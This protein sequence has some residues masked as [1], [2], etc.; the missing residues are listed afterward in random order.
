MPDFISRETLIAD[1]GYPCDA[2]DWVTNGALAGCGVSF[3]D[4]RVIAEAKHNGW[5]ILEG[6]EYLK[7]VVVCGGKAN[8]YRAI[9]E[10]Y[11]VINDYGVF[12]DADY[13]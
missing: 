13:C 3:G 12:D 5:N 7:I 10:V 4:L 11:R 1:R 6:E 8:I 9:P 2:C